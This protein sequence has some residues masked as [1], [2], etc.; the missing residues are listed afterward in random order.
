MARDSV[1][2]TAHPSGLGALVTCPE[3]GSDD[4]VAVMP[5]GEIAFFCEECHRC[6]HVELGYVQRVDP[7]TCPGCAHRRE[8][9]ERWRA[10]HR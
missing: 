6:W 4:L 5:D 8:C 7:T 1:P 9:L 10:D 2:A 3:C